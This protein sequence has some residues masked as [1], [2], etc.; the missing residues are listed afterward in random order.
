ME[1]V[2]KSKS[3]C[4]STPRTPALRTRCSVSRDP[5]GGSLHPGIG[6]VACLT[7]FKGL[8]PASFT[9]AHEVPSRGKDPA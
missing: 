7:G 1:S 8:K 5:S 3:T 4:R 2:V 9:L 6:D